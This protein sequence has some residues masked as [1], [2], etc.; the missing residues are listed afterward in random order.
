MWRRGNFLHDTYTYTHTRIHTHTLPGQDRPSFITDSVAVNPNGSGHRGICFTLGFPLVGHKMIP[1]RRQ[2]LLTHF[3]RLPPPAPPVFVRVGLEAV[4]VPSLLL[5]PQLL[6]TFSIR[7]NYRAAQRLYRSRVLL[8]S[9]SP[10]LPQPSPWKPLHSHR[11]A[12]I[13]LKVQLPPV[14]YSP[15]TNPLT[16]GGRV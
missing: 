7:A 10:W 9:S 11:H 15:E 1:V 3:E 13:S 8:S 16:Q 12:L 6:R 4:E 2:Y 5:V 14:C